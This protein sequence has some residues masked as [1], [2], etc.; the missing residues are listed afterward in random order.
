MPLVR[1]TSPPNS[2]MGSFV[3]GGNNDQHDQS[4]VTGVTGVSSCSRNSAHTTNSSHSADSASGP[5][6]STAGLVGTPLGPP[7][8][9]IKKSEGQRL[10]LLFG[11]S[12]T[13]YLLLMDED[14]GSAHWQTVLHANLPRGLED[15]IV[16]ITERSGSISDVAFS[17]DGRWYVQARF[18]DDANG[19][20][21]MSGAA[22]AGAAGG[23]PGGASSVPGRAQ[24]R[25][26]MGSMRS[27]RAGSI[28][29]SGSGIFSHAVNGGKV[30]GCKKTWWGGTSEKVS[31]ALEEWSKSNHRL[32]VSFGDEG[33]C[34]LLQGDNGHWDCGYAKVEPGLKSRVDRRYKDG[35]KID[36][37]RL[38]PFYSCSDSYV[39]SDSE[40]TKW[41]GLCEHLANEL[42][43]AAA[44][45]TVCDVTMS[46]DQAWVVVYPHHF[47]ESPGV[48]PNL[49]QEMK[50]FMARQRVRRERREREL[51]RFK[52]AEAAF[53]EQC[54]RETR[55]AEA[56]EA[57]R[58]TLRAQRERDDEELRELR[59]QLE[60]EKMGSAVR[61]LRV[62]MR[63]TVNPPAATA[64]S[65]DGAKPVDSASRGCGG[66]GGSVHPGDA[67][68]ASVE[69]DR[70]H[71]RHEVTVRYDDG[72]TQVVTDVSTIEIFDER[73]RLRT[74]END[75]ARQRVEY[76]SKRLELHARKRRLYLWRG[77]RPDECAS[78]PAAGAAVPPAAMAAASVSATGG[79]FPAGA[80][81]GVHAA[82]AT[83]SG[84]VPKDPS[85]SLSL[86]DALLQSAS[87]SSS[88]YVHL[89]L[90][91]EAAVYYA[92]T[93]TTLP[94][95]NAN[96]SA[97]AVASQSC[98][99]A[100]VDHSLV[101]ESDVYDLS[102]AENCASH[103]VRD[104]RAVRYA[105]DHRV[106]LVRGYV[107]P[108]AVVGVHDLRPLGVPRNPPS[109]LVGQQAATAGGHGLQGQQQ[110]RGV[111]APEY[112]RQLG[113]AVPGMPEQIAGWVRSGSQRLLEEECQRMGSS[114][115]GGTMAGGK[116]TCYPDHVVA[117]AV[118]RGSVR[119]PR[120]FEP[121]WRKILGGHR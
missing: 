82:A 67:V 45:E 2:N 56:L 70:Q 75:L 111:P 50:K 42:R 41:F 107:P 28:G 27:A 12:P 60:R 7:P 3:G 30:K 4:V 49:V 94:P 34:F 106:V 58:R 39:V 108:E 61:G 47:V 20:E 18:P 86:E 54:L 64:L 119:A 87:G 83:R 14:D 121:L 80:A 84:I 115:G 65:V 117:L 116:G 81:A 79:A 96:P 59:A 37:I 55:L 63:I 5:S 8:R 95:A 98:R 25:N 118:V 105:V 15:Q 72:S 26:S 114:T 69:T 110:A 23:V 19:L 16:R 74:I 31:S 68:I 100:Q 102:T 10:R 97:A 88:Q 1:R 91:A 6:V 92:A 76:R 112:L 13:S 38:F 78:A 101:S 109:S 33:Q 35:G 99:V 113:E 32:Q 77:L 44:E 62:G 43:H 9:R 48:C 46:G 11:D 40:G 57:E 66:G 29:S 53:R 93:L 104:A 22:S 71:G 90:S 103:G 21:C 89:T 17:P 24:R 52:E 73:S 36:F 51:S 85:A 120:E